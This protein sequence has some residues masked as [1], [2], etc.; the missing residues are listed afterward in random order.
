[1]GMRDIEARTADAVARILKPF[2]AADLRHKAVCGLVET[3]SLLR[4]SDSAAAVSV[5]GPADL[6]DAVRAG[7]AGK[8]D[9]VSFH[10]G[11]ACDVQVTVGRTVLE[12]RLGS[13]LARVGEAGA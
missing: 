1:Q 11:Q 9:N 12:T 3:L 8:L 7:L 4:T 10:P 6:L 5:T 2:L 13:W